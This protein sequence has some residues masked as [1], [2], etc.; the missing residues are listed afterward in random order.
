[1]KNSSDIISTLPDFLARRVEAR[2]AGYSSLCWEWSAALHL[3]YGWVSHKGNPQLA[4]RLAYLV[5]HGDIPPGLVIDH[6]CRNR[7]CINPRHLEAVTLAVNTRRAHPNYIDDDMTFCPRG[8]ALTEGFVIPAS[9]GSRRCLRCERGENAKPY[10]GPVALRTTC[11]K[12]HPYSGDNLYITPKGS[13]VC[14]QCRREGE[15]RRAAK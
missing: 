2:F 13:K 14:R 8:H 4:H 5:V 9:N 7:R 6:L 1:M 12:G 3:G 11:P 10:R 15:R